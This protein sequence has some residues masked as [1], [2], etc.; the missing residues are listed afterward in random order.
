MPAAARGQNLAIAHRWAENK[1][2]RRP[3]LAAELVLLT[4]PSRTPAISR[5]S[6]RVAFSSPITGIVCCARA[7]TGQA[8]A[9]P[10]KT[11]SGAASRVK[12]LDHLKSDNYSTLER[13][14]V[15]SSQ[16]VGRRPITA[17]GHPETCPAAH[18]IMLAT[19]LAG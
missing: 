15:D 17:P 3:S 9:P 12:P 19:G 16:V 4:S 1:I 7:A 8:A 5:G 18:A 11:M 10:S 13:A 14:R 2:D 6:S